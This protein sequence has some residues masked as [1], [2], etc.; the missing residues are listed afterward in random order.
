MTYI[1][2]SAGRDAFRYSEEYLVPL[3]ANLSEALKDLSGQ[4][5]MA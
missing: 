2:E 4:E 3:L 5:G 1:T